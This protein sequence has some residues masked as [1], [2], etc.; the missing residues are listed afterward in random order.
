MK[1]PPK[2][3]TTSVNIARA[4]LPQRCSRCTGR[5]DRGDEYVIE[6]WSNA[7]GFDYHHADCASTSMR[8]HLAGK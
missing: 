7:G 1:K 8:T 6:P 4:D 2:G 3:A 5:I